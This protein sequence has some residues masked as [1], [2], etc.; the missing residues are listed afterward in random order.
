[1]GLEF[2]LGHAPRDVLDSGHGEAAG[3]VLAYRLPE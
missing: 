1:V 2:F 3:L